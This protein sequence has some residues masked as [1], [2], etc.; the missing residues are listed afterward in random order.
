MAPRRAPQHLS[1]GGRPRA[2]SRT[3]TRFA[4]QFGQTQS[5]LTYQER[6]SAYGIC[7][8]GEA[9]IAIVQIGK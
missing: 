9:N 4:L 6:M 3:M 5:G 7:A 1:P 8:R 2:I